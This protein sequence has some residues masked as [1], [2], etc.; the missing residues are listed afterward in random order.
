MSDLPRIPVRT[1]LTVLSADKPRDREIGFMCYELEGTDVI[2]PPAG[3]PNWPPTPANKLS[4]ETVTAWFNDPGCLIT[5]EDG[6]ID[7]ERLL[8]QDLIGLNIG[9]VSLQKGQEPTCTSESGNTSFFLTFVHDRATVPGREHE[10]SRWACVGS[11]NLKGLKRL[12]L[13]DKDSET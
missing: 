6:L 4:A 3:H 11:A 9:I 7:G 12:Q 5:T 10:P 2:R 8:I 1:E 13:F